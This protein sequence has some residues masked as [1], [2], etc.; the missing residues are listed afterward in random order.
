MTQNVR[1]RGKIGPW[2]V[3]VVLE[4]EGALSLLSRAAES[5]AQPAVATE[6]VPATAENRDSVLDDLLLA[7]REHGA[8]SGSALL[9]R[10][11]LKIDGGKSWLV[12]LRH[13]PEV[14]VVACDG[15]TLYRMKDSSDD[16]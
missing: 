12:R 3:D 16:Q 1:V 5:A 15:V 4:W 8:Q 7:L 2:D 9:A 6:A 14:S 13:H 10:V 11:G